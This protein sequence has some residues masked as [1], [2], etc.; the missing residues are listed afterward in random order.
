MTEKIVLHWLLSFAKTSLYL[1]LVAYLFY[2]SEKNDLSKTMK[3][4]A[5]LTV[6]AIEVAWTSLASLLLETNETLKVAKK[7]KEEY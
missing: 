7:K 3:V 2:R 4:A 1:A 6:F 5:V